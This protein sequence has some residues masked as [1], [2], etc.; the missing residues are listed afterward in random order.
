[1]PVQPVTKEIKVTRAQ[2]VTRA[3]RVQ[4]AAL[5]LPAIPVQPATKEIKVTR[6]QQV[7]P[8]PH[9]TNAS[10]SVE[11]AG[12][13]AQSLVAAITRRALPCEA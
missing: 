13:V 12:L 8:G 6:A 10:H 4:R 2:Q 1:M 5:V 11:Y 7:I 9:P 3:V